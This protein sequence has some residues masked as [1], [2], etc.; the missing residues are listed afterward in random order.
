MSLAMD[1][2]LLR[3]QGPQKAPEVACGQQPSLRICNSTAKPMLQ[4]YYIRG[5]QRY[6]F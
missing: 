3:K 4:A 1:G 5:L 2:I 6:H